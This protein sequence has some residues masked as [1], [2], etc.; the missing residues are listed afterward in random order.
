MIGVGAALDVLVGVYLPI[1]AAVA[2]TLGVAVGSLVS[3][4]FGGPAS[5]PSAAAVLDALDD[6]GLDIVALREV[7]PA[8][9]GPSVYVATTID[10]SAL[11]VRV[12][13][14]DDRDRD[15]LTRLYRWFAVGDRQ[16]DQTPVTA[17]SAVEHELLAK[18]SG[19]RAGARI[20]EPVVAYPVGKPGGHRGALLAW[21]AV[22]GRRLDLVA[23]DA[24]SDEALADLWTSVARL[25]QHRLAHRMLRTDHLILDRTDRVW[26]TGLTLAKLGATP[27]DLATD[28]AELLASLALQVGVP[29]SVRAALAGLGSERLIAALPYL[30]PL[31][32]VGPTLTRGADLRP[33]SAARLAPRHPAAS[34]PPPAARRSSQLAGR[35]ARRGHQGN[36]DVRRRS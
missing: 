3:L 5:R 12:L 11:T 35:S 10:D 15:W 21:V 17:E 6:C 20:P 7:T 16:D 13:G 27:R 4:L 24:L 29:R 32:M 8:P 19:A 22:G 2:A 26:I 33:G 18:V 1:D 31:A 30:Q 36:R 23:D 28:V 34:S 25:Q 9:G 14:R